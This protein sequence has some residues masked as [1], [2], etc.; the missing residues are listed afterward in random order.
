MK[1]TSVIQLLSAALLAC[2][3]ISG[4]H[5]AAAAVT[6]TAGDLL[7]GFQASGGTGATST[8]VYNLGAAT[9]YR[10][11]TTTGLI[12]NLSTDLTA[13]FGDNWF[14][15]DDLYWGIAGVR[16]AN[17]GGAIGLVDG[18]PRAAIYISRSAAA[19]GSS[20]AW[21][22]PADGGDPNRSNA[23][24]NV[25]GSIASFQTSFAGSL[26]TANSGGLGTIQNINTTTNDWS[27]FNPI[28]DAAFG[29]VLTGGVQGALGGT[30]AYLDL[31]RLLGRA[32]DGATPNSAA[33]EGHYITTFSIDAAG[34]VSA[35]VVPEPAGALLLG[36]G[37][38]TL[39]RRRRQA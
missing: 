13:V 7:L 10:D 33:G 32:N 19:P 20:T 25:A 39:L 28:G 6:Y 18:D 26:E 36:L 35:F 29:G 22:L 5:H 17:G 12:S 23:T 8:Y 27:E 31:Y 15:R 34:N 37:A 1:R 11:G 14:S 3:T 30:E 24:I 16:D 9:D 38:A 21:V 4:T 2:G